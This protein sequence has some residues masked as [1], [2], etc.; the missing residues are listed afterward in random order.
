MFLRPKKP[1]AVHL[2][3]HDAVPSLREAIMR[4]YK[5]REM[6]LRLARM[7][8][9]YME[10]RQAEL[11]AVIERLDAGTAAAEKKGKDAAESRT[12]PREGGPWT[13]EKN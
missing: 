7:A 5:D 10:D 2:S 11:R 4:R 8:I 12:E 1:G 6:L 3:A 13:P 9:D